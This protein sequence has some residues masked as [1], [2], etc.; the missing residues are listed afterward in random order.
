MGRGDDAPEQLA[1][2]LAEV[3]QRD[4]EAVPESG[5]AQGHLELT[6]AMSQS[7]G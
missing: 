3:R 4:G 5:A 2:R 1:A 6:K 7:K